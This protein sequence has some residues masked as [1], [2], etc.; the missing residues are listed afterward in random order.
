MTTTPQYRY[1]GITD[2][3]QECECCGKKN[4]KKTVVLSL[5]D[6]EGVHE[7][8]VRYGTT[9][10]ARALG[11]GSGAKVRKLAENAHQKTAETAKHARELLAAYGLPEAGEIDRRT[12]NLAARKYR[13]NHFGAAWAADETWDGWKTR[14]LDMAQRMRAALAE[15]ALIGA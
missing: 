2:E 1:I 13:Y 14:T 7:H 3:C 9:C 12:L 10:A 15:A 6:A 8:Y 5:C 11:A 4:L